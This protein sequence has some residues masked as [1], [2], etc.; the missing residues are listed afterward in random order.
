MAKTRTSARAHWPSL[1]EQLQA[2]EIKRGSALESLIRNNQ[3][4]ELLSPEEAHDDLGFP[5]W[6]RVYF[7]KAH[8]EI[9]FSGGRMG[10]PLILKEVLGYMLRHQDQP[11]G[12]TGQRPRQ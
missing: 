2:L 3:N 6:L 12:G 8:P 4:F 1:D 10:Y 11:E 7:R 5:P 9:D